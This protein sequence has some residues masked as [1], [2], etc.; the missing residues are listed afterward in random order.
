MSEA[1][2]SGQTVVIVG[3]GHG[4][5]QAVVSLRQE[6]W[7]GRI[8]LIGEEPYLPYQRPPLSK[9]FLAGEI[10]IDRV[11]F[12]AEESYG[13][14]NANVELKLNTR[15][16]AIDRTAKTVTTTD[17][18][19][20]SY[21]KLLLTTGSRVRR[22]DFLPGAD[23]D[24][25]CYLRGID[26]VENIKRFFGSGKKAVIV[27]AGYIGLEVAAVAV[28]NGVDVTVLEM[29]ER[30]MARVTAPLVSDFYH[31]VHTEEGVKI[32]YGVKVT[33]FEKND[34]GELTKVLTEGGETFDADFA[35]IG[36]GIIP[37]VEL[38]E[39]AGLPC[40]NGIL[41][42]DCARTEDPD[43]FAAGD[44]TNHPN[45]HLGKNIRLESVQNALEQSKSA[46]AAICGKEKPY[47]QVPWFWSDQYDLK[48]QIVGLSQ[49]YTDVVVRGNPDARAFAAFYLKDGELI[50]VDA[51]NAAPEFLMS[52]RLIAQKAH[53]D[54]T[55]L[56]D[57]SIPM[58]EVL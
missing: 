24:G 39:A 52:K 34:A 46:A 13:P 9:K 3:A 5:G 42:D 55:R 49:G 1:A 37:N 44:C 27:G 14:D 12:K 4:S 17:G 31:K 19:T 53:P 15:V 25:V 6:G 50:A 29:E 45:G 35:V 8:V 2:T 51:I 56:A 20:I 10:G 11:E 54:P 43:V 26:D 41:V 47:N 18:E 23:A 28:K 33:G 30:P 22:L 36:V 57:T 58:K 21:D 40:D 16:E 48:L 38:A 7:E 32:C